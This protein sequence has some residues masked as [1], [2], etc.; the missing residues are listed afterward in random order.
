[1]LLL[2][3]QVAQAEDYHLVG[4]VI[5][6]VPALASYGVTPGAAVDVSWTVDLSTPASGVS[7]PPDN[8]SDYIG[9]L[10]FLVIQIGTWVAVRVAPSMG[11]IEQGIVSVADD[12]GGS[13]DLLHIATPG[14]DNDL[15]LHGP[16]MGGV[17]I[18]S[19]DFYALNGEASSNQSLDQDPDLYP[20]GV[21][22]AIGQNGYVT[23]RLNGG[24]GGGGSG[25]GSGDPTA[26]CDS[27]HLGAGGRMCQS[28][29]RCQSSYAKAPDRD[30]GANRRDA[31]MNAAGQTF[32]AAYNDALVTAASDGLTC[33]T[34][35]PAVDL[36]E[37]ITERV[38]EIVDDVN[39]II[40]AHAPLASAWLG[41]AGTACGAVLKAEATNA[42]KPDAGKL[43]Q[44]RAKAS[45]KL[46]GSAGK[47]S[48]K[49]AKGVVFDPPLDVDAF[50]DSVAAAVD[51]TAEDLSGD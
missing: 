31:C 36:R 4:E 22:S 24:G 5:D 18:L 42:A 43:A 10:D 12:S 30:P 50:V 27:A 20:L 21:G 44:A 38:D 40:P 28:Q 32:T 46:E 33:G 25:G 17:L 1:M 2:A 19:L 9:A 26:A 35:E 37:A 51:A 3:A 41:A 34:T 7:G 6:A 14:T 48:D 29:F 15:V 13:L 39:T 23:F 47:A 16:A 8:K 11:Q 49:A 45:D